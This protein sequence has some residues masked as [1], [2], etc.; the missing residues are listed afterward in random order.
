VIKLSD[1]GASKL[2]S[3]EGGF[4]EMQSH[5]CHTAIGT[6]QFMAPEVY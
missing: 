5:A 4:E 2:T 3:F 1:F 6:M